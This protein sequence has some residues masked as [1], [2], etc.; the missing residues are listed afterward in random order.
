MKYQFIINPIAGG[1]L[2]KKKW[3]EI[4]RVVET[5]NLN[6]EVVVTSSSGDAVF[7]AKKGVEKGFDVLVAVGGDGTVNEVVQGIIESGGKGSVKLGIIPAGTG[8]DL[9]RTLNIP[10][11]AEEAVKVLKNGH[12]KNIDLGK[13][14]GDY[15]INIVGIG[16]DGAVANEINRDVRWL[17]GSSAYIYAILKTLL[18]YKSPKMKITIDDLILKGR[19]FLVAIG[20]A[21]YYGGGIKILP[22]ANPS[23]GLFDICV[24][25]D[26]PRIEVLKMLPKMSKGKHLDHSAVK[27]YRGKKIKVDS[28]EKVLVQADGELKGALPM[29]F[30]VEANVIPVLV[31]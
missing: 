4:K 11:H 28:D 5:E 20:N 13:I 14:N 19:Y 25:E 2:A 10:T 3:E 16:F 27:I 15:F 29:E 31:P 24:V 21:R 1:G 12:V 8:N 30:E 7:I 9:V 26:I 6:Y 18:T 17:K 22:D 23:D